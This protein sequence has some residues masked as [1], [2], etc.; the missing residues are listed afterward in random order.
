MFSPIIERKNWKALLET[1]RLEL[2]GEVRRLLPKDE[3]NPLYS[4]GHVMFCGW[5]KY[6]HHNGKLTVHEQGC[7]RLTPDDIDELPIE[8]L[9][10]IHEYLR[11][12]NENLSRR[13]QNHERRLAEVGN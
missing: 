12:Y 1:K 7:R 6:V 9:A 8:A 4:P 11:D 3:K 10:D 2:L 5:V 13:R